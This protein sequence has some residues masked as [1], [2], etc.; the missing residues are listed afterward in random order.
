[1]RIPEDIFQAV[2]AHA[3]QHERT[4]SDEVRALLAAHYEIQPVMPPLPAILGWQP[5][6]LAAPAACEGCG[7]ARQSGDAMFVGITRED[8]MRLVVCADCKLRAESKD[9]DDDHARC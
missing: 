2:K 1:V 4:I 7:A 3:G 9:T 8:P 6:T 5:F